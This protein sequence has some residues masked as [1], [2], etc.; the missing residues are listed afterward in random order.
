MAHDPRTPKAVKYLIY[1]G[2]VYTI[3]PIDLLPDWIPGLGLIDD[4]AVVPSIIA[5]AMVMIPKEV[6]QDADAKEEIEIA[7]S[8]KTG[9][10]SIK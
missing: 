2:I 9:Q 5:L 6:K 10:K 1:G 3:S 8:Q 7:E 4:A